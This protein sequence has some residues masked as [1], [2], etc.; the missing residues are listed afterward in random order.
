MNNKITTIHELI[1][2]KKSNII[3]AYDNT[4]FPQL[5]HLLSKIHPY[6]IG[7]KI[8]NEILNLNDQQNVSLYNLCKCYSI[9]N[10]ISNTVIK[11][12]KK[13]EPVRDFVSICPTCGPDI[14]KIKSS[15]GFFVLIEMSSDN[16]L[17][18]NLTNK[19]YDWVIQEKNNDKNSICGIICQSEKY[20]NI[21]SN[22]NDLITIKPGIH[23]TNTKDD[24]GQRYTNP[25]NIKNKPTL[26]VIG[27][28]ITQAE[29][30]IEELKKYLS[31]TYTTN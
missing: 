5:C 12:L 25:Q 6:I 10:D 20:F 24:V 8:H 28:G 13:Y 27:R 19:L 11:Q 7:L 17:F 9:F 21:H 29:K 15:L 26:F 3:L 18:N 4:D 2:K 16:N 22:N 30:P 14:L 23:L 1:S 31:V